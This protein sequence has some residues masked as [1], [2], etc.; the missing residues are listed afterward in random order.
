MK[1][2]KRLL[3]PELDPGF[4]LEAT[5]FLTFDPNQRKLAARLA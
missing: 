1:R 2:D 5:V 3:Y 4:R